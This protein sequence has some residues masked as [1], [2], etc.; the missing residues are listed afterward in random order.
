MEALK[1]NENFE[2]R[3][4]NFHNAL[5]ISVMIMQN[6]SSRYGD[7]CNQ[8]I[9]RLNFI[10]RDDVLAKKYNFKACKFDCRE[11]VP[12]REPLDDVSPC[13]IHR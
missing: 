2:L 9:S 13:R 8:F 7:D 11:S 6:L 5:Y 10:E 12:G 4:I 3:I 1:A